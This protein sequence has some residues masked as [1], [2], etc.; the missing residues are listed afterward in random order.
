VTQVQSYARL[1]YR[2][3]T[4]W[5]AGIGQE[6]PRFLASILQ[7]ANEDR[8]TGCII[9]G[10]WRTISI[11]RT[12]HGEKLRLL[13]GSGGHGDA[14]DTTGAGTW[15]VWVVDVVIVVEVGVVRRGYA[16]S[17]AQHV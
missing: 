10:Q 3:L 7:R 11:S 4:C 16:S 15:D 9:Y 8:N 14:A 17:K 13:V 12:G 1:E 2:I 6:L 5:R